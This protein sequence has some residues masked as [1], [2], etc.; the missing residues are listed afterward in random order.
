MKLEQNHCIWEHYNGAL[1][2]QTPPHQNITVSED[3]QKMLFNQS[4]AYF[5]RWTDDFDTPQKTPFWYIL[6]DTREGLETYSSKMRYQ[7]KK[8]MTN[9]SVSPTTV[10][11]IATEGYNVFSNALKHYS[12]TPQTI[13]AKAFATNILSLDETWEFW[14]VRNHTG[15]LIAYS[16]NRIMD[17]TCN[18]STIKLD[19]VYLHLY[20]A[21]ALFFSMNMHYLNERKMRYVHDGSR[22]LSHESNI[23]DFLCDKFKFRK[24]YC[25]MHIAYR[26]DIALIVKILYPFNKI[27]E[28][29]PF[30]WSHKLSVLLRHEKIRRKT[31]YL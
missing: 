27:L 24:A 25:T 21:Y 29:F 14:E 13:T 19:P 11:V 9:C 10:Q 20:P 2:P 15:D 26:P 22:S 12:N 23:Q 1:L 31:H 17:N 6:K 7:I 30:S 28:L 8:G 3:D 16:Q 18:Y 4:N 5:L